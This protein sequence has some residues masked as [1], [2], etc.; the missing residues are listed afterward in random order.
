MYNLRADIAHDSQLLDTFEA[1]YHNQALARE[2]KVQEFVATILSLKGSSEAE[3]ATQDL[4]RDSQLQAILART[5]LGQHPSFASKL[6]VG[7]RLGVTLDALRNGNKNVA[8]LSPDNP[9]PSL[10]F[11]DQPSAGP[12]RQ[13]PILQDSEDESEEEEFDEIAGSVSLPPGS[14]D[15]GSSEEES[16]EEK[17]EVPPVSQGKP[18][19]VTRRTSSRLN[20]PSSSQK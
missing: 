7:K 8:R 11:V 12:S 19:L 20:L 16:D 2:L 6:E 18:D 4:L 14:Q 17:A 15:V 10:D 1:L 9:V 13:P 3:A 5:D